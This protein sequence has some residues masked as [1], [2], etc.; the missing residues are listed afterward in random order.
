MTVML[1]PHFTLAEMTV[2]RTGMA[3]TPN[4]VQIEALRLLCLELEAWRAIAG[5]LVVTSGFR[6]PEV[7]RAVHGSRTSQHLRGEAA[8]VIPARGRGPAWDTLVELI[9]CGFPVDQAIIYEDAPHIHISHTVRYSP[10]CQ[11]LVHRVDGRYVDWAGYA[12]VLRV[13][14]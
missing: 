1:S 5:P 4:G 6:S 11:I 14:G 13:A 2:T 9:A 3:N 8:D 10:R 7:N 12:G